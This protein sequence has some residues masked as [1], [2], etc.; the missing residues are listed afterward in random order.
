MILT[1]QRFYLQGTHVQNVGSKRAFCPS[2]ICWG[3]QHTCTF[4]LGASRSA[5]SLRPLFHRNPMTWLCAVRT[6]LVLQQPWLK[7]IFSPAKVWKNGHMQLCATVN[8]GSL[9]QAEALH[10]WIFGTCWHHHPP[11]SHLVEWHNK[12]PEL[13]KNEAI[14]WQF[15]PLTGDI[16]IYP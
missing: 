5:S 8:F 10:R 2:G 7:I 14:P 9:G 1:Y 11:A 15:H 13:A 12:W 4:G 3:S 16:Y 6:H